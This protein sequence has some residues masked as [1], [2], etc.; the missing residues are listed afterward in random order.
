MLGLHF[1]IIEIRKQDYNMSAGIIPMYDRQVS[2]S[3]QL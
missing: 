2:A 1:S 3:M